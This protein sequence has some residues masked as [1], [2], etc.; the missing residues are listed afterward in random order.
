MAQAETQVRLYDI[1]LYKRFS[2][3]GRLQQLDIALHRQ[4][5][6]EIQKNP[7]LSLCQNINENEAR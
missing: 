1:K 7:P 2:V 4:L 3:S 5:I 6:K